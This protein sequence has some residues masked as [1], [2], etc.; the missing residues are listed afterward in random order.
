MQKFQVEEK[1]RKI[2][3]NSNSKGAGGKAAKRPKV[4]NEVIIIYLFN[5]Q[6]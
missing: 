3:A 2:A 1:K 5:I 4:D 6:P